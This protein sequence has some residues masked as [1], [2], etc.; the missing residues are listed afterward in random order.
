MRVEATYCEARIWRLCAFV[1]LGFLLLGGCATQTDY[2]EPGLRERVERLKLEAEEGTSPENFS[3]RTDVLWDWANAY[4][5]TGG[6][7]PVN[8][9]QAVSRARIAQ[10]DGVAASPE[11]LR[12][13]DQYIREL[14]IKD[15]RPDALGSLRFD[16]DEPLVA[17]SWAT[18]S[19]TYAIGSEAMVEGGGILLAR[20]LLTGAVYPQHQ[21]SA[22]DHYVLVRCSNPDAAFKKTVTPVAGMHGGFRAAQG[23]A[24][25][26]LEGTKL[27]AGETITVVY[28]D[29]TGGSR[30]IR[31]QYTP[32][33]ELLF[34]FYV[35]LEGKG[36]YLTPRWP[37]KVVIGEAVESAHGFAPSVVGVNEA[38]ELSIRSEDL[39]LNR[40]SG[41]IPEYQVFLNGDPFAR[42]P[43]GAEAIHV[44]SEIQIEQ[45]GIYRFTFQ[46][47]DGSIRG[48]SNPVWVRE[49][50]A[51][52]IYWGET[53][54]HT[55]FAEGQGSAE[56][57]FKFG[58]EESRL[59]FLCLSE[60]DI[61]L[62]DFEWKTLQELAQKYYMEG[63]FV[64]FLGYEWTMRRSRGGHHNV[65]FRTPD[66]ARVAAQEANQLPL[67]YQ[68]LRR[69]NDPRD[70]LIIPHAHQAGD[71]TQSD[72]EMEK[73]VEIYSMH[74]TFEWFGNMYLQNGF[75]VGF[76]AASD[77][78]RAKPGY[79]HGFWGSSPLE[80]LP[81]LAAVLAPE[82]T[83][84]A[85]FDG[86]RSLSA[87]ATSGQRIVLDA[88]LNGFRMGTRQ[89]Q[90]SARSI[91]CN[92]MGTA[93]IDQIDV[94]KN[95]DVVFSQDYLSTPL[96]SHTWIEVGFESTSGVFGEQRD[97][98]RPYRPWVGTMEVSGARVVSVGTAGF[99][100]RHFERAEVDSANPNLIRFHVETRGRRDSMLVELEGAGAGTNFRFHL[101]SR[102]ED[103][104]SLTLVR[105]PVLLPESQFTLRLADLQE[106][107]I[108]HELPIDK[109]TDTVSLSVIDPNGPM[110]QEF[111]FNDLEQPNPGD[112]YYVRVRQLDGGRAWSSPFWVGD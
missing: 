104:L 57:F 7:I 48:S 108:E 83:R 46:S 77:T 28:G 8:L 31:I 65:L 49:D 27:R 96:T 58:L 14:Q 101:E 60:H 39:F 9:P 110:D 1:A 76:I 59:D 69:D 61:W 85:I 72:P 107:K 84:D 98:P 68:G 38:F 11:L 75:E 44:L 40:A 82:K 35:D 105:A 97:N 90:T 41:A 54:A 80:Q 30:G 12:Q 29:K 95:G 81:G 25:F 99:D 52:R 3:T 70:V 100:N 87:Y 19:Q 2:L 111:E 43:A 89:P 18:F 47:A 22:A 50:P 62:D 20:Q 86:L 92:V 36:N 94:V 5:L 24:T 63:R 45:P 106:N 10:T 6:P 13:I 4:A 53:H 42:I 64:P 17:G 16:S 103:K 33:D 71:W 66:K 109:H 67:L 102:R 73:L 21:D 74:G 88:Q 112:Y 91:A 34:P 23:M 15:E 37:K 26:V 32:T 78:H 56:S 55:G 79:V 93:P 51:H